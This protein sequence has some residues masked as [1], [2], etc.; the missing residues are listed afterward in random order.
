MIELIDKIDLL[1]QELA[2][3]K[4]KSEGLRCELDI[5]DELHFDEIAKAENYNNWLIAVI[6][7]LALWI[8]TG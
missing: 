7:I 8:A 1:E 4:F 6:V 5:S 2:M 3:E